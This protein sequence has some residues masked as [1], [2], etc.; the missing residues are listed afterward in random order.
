MK[1]LILFLI[2][3][4]LSKLTFATGIGYALSGGGAR[5]FAH[6]GILKVLEEEGLAPHYISGTSIGA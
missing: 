4:S 5:G 1:R 3:C 6:I 2:F